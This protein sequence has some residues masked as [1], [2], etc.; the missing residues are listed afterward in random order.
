MDQ[1]V[2]SLEVAALRLRRPGPVLDGGAPLASPRSI[3][4]DAVCEDLV[5]SDLLVDRVLPE[6]E[7]K[8][9]DQAGGRL[10]D[11]GE[12]VA[13]PVLDVVRV[14]AVVHD[15]KGRVEACR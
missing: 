12:L 1:R 8:R 3:D 9:Q 15:L 7:S 14:N 4:L 11:G 2:A 6:H 5:C 13:Q 10:V